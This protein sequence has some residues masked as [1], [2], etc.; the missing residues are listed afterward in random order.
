MGSISDF[1]TDC[2][3]SLLIDKQPIVCA[4]GLMMKCSIVDNTYIPQQMISF[5]DFIVS[6]RR[7][8][9]ILKTPESSP[10]SMNPRLMKT[11]L[12]FPCAL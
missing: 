4:D 10:V 1:D 7:A 11:S 8:I 12:L 5:D 3:Y 2:S 6:V 9:E